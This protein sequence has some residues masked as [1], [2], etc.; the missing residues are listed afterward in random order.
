MPKVE[1]VYTMEAEDLDDWDKLD[2]SFELLDAIGE[3]GKVWL[4]IARRKQQRI[5]VYQVMISEGEE[6]H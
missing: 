1:A 6:L 5:Y 4:T 2:D 3:E